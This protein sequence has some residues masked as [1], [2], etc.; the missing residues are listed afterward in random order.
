MFRTIGRNRGKSQPVRI[1]VFEFNSLDWRISLRPNANI[2]P[3]PKVEFHRIVKNRAFGGS[4]RQKADTTGQFGPQKPLEK[5][6]IG[7]KM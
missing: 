6:A 2:L 3:N 7:A 1:A 5:A 4:M